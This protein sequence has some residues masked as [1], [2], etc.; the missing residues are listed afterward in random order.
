MKTRFLKWFIPTSLIAS[1]FAITTPLLTSC[2]FTI[3][4]PI[5]SLPS[6]EY[7]RFNFY[8]NDNNKYITF[9]ISE[10]PLNQNSSLEWR[11]ENKVIEPIKTDNET[12]SN[13]IQFLA[14]AN[15]SVFIK[16]NNDHTTYYHVATRYIT[17]ADFN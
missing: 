6:D 7:K 10:L 2:S 8:S 5:Q 17:Y 4:S 12:Y 16:I 14:P 3:N 1:S 15:Y 13:V 11:V 9:D